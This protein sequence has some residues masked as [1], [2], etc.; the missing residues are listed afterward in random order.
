MMSQLFMNL[1]QHQNSL[2]FLHFLPALR[3][4]CAFSG[5]SGEVKACVA[6]VRGWGWARVNHLK[7]LCAKTKLL[8]AWVF[9]R[10][11]SA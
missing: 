2:A 7:V 1:V 3:A 10:G 5:L 9:C 4:E 6:D 11:E 8:E